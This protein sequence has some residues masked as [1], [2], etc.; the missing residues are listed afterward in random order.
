MSNVRLFF[1]ES[2]SLNLSSKLNKVSISLSYKSNES[3][4][5]RVLFIIQSKRR[6][7]SKINEISKGI[8]EF[9]VLKN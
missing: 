4:S 8:V 3:K 7:G 6:M 9:T 1:S 2:L 5:W